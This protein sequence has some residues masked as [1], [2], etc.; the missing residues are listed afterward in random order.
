[1]AI[2]RQLSGSRGVCAVSLRDEQHP[3]KESNGYAQQ[4]AIFR[5]EVLI[6]PKEGSIQNLT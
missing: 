2:Y 4:L 5:P 3:S 1:M 6:M